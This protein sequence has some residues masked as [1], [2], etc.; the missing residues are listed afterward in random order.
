MK[1][2]V[3]TNYD[4]IIEIELNVKTESTVPI[5]NE[6]GLFVHKEY[7][8][9]IYMYFPIY[10]NNNGALLGNTRVDFSRQDIEK[11]Y[12]EIK[13]IDTKEHYLPSIEDN[14]PF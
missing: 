12:N 9:K 10:D 11:M 2:L 5:K 7:I 6:D 3:N 4:T 14:L 13:E 8:R 1:R